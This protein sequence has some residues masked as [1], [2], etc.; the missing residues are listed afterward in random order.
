MHVCTYLGGT[1]SLTE[2][3]SPSAALLVLHP[4]S[5]WRRNKNS[6]LENTG[7]LTV[8][9]TCTPTATPPSTLPATEREEFIPFCSASLDHTPRYGGAQNRKH[10]SASTQPTPRVG[11][12]KTPPHPQSILSQA[13][14]AGFILQE[15]LQVSCSNISIIPACLVTGTVIGRTRPSAPPQP[16]QRGN[17]LGKAPLQ[18]TAKLLPN[19]AGYKAG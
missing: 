9:C 14:W 8:G 15:L 19:A 3:P 16:Q 12:A 13:P 10:F 11:Q 17:A 2:P 1:C 7:A 4:V 6:R 5:V 18:P